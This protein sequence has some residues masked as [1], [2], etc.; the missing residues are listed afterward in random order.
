MKRKCICPN[1]GKSR[2]VTDIRGLGPC[3]S[4]S[5]AFRCIKII[6][7]LFFFFFFFFK[8][9]ILFFKLYIISDSL[10][11]VTWPSPNN[12]EVWSVLI[13][14]SWITCLTPGAERETI[15][16]SHE[17]NMYEEVD[18]QVKFVSYSGR[19]GNR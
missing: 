6:L 17:T 5:L 3:L 16:R 7:I 8:N 1:N 11:L 4:L 18:S 2:T 13:H 14:Q 9:F 10:E 12:P 15:S 19:R